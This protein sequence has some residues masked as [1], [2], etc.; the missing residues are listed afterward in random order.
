MEIFY[1]RLPT[2][3]R[4]IELQCGVFRQPKPVSQLVSCSQANKSE[5]QCKEWLTKGEHVDR[6]NRQEA[7]YQP[8]LNTHR[9]PFTIC[10]SKCLFKRTYRK[11]TLYSH[12]STCIYVCWQVCQ[13][14]CVSMQ[15]CDFSKQPASSTHCVYVYMLV[16]LYVLMLCSCYA[17]PCQ[18]TTV[19][20]PRTLIYSH[21]IILLYVCMCACV[22]ACVASYSFTICLTFYYFFFQ[23]ILCFFLF[24]CNIFSKAS[25]SISSIHFSLYN[26]EVFFFRFCFLFRTFVRTCN[27]VVPHSYVCAYAMRV[28]QLLQSHPLDSRCNKLK[29]NQLSNEKLRP[30]NIVELLSLR[31][32]RKQFTSTEAG[33]TYMHTYT[34]IC[35]HNA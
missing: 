21:S 19:N 1:K 13:S 28:L 4:T 20:V 6:Q 25:F 10:A 16:R 5:V 12:V 11:M 34:C 23:C 31:K 29:D 18:L 24:F 33:T 14:V 22:G 3:S 35:I 8:T 26:Y 15:F 7:F 9:S 30:C 27:G 2:H 17:K 32:R